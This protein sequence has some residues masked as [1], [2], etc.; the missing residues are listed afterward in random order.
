MLPA[1]LLG[2]VAATYLHKKFPEA[3]EKVAGGV[4]AAARWA[5]AQAVAC[6]E[7]QQAKLA[8]KPGEDGL[9]TWERRQR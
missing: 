1:L 3:T 8:Q 2:G 5:G 9:D 4:M 7:S 6:L